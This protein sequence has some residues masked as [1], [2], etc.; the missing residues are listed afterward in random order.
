MI[1]HQKCGVI[2]GAS[3]Q[4]SNLS[5]AATEELDGFVARVNVG[6]V[7]LQ[8]AT[9]RSG[10]QHRRGGWMTDGQRGSQSVPLIAVDAVAIWLTRQRVKHGPLVSRSGREMPTHS[11]VDG[12]TL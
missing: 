12:V 7:D 4:K 2:N 9:I 3:E 8:V 5:A 11:Q 1:T 6:V 10:R